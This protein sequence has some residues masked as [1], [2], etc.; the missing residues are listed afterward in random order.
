MTDRTGVLSS[1]LLFVKIGS[2]LFV[3]SFASLCSRHLSCVCA[4][5]GKAARHHNHY[6]HVTSTGTRR[7]ALSIIACAAPATAPSP[8]LSSSFPPPFPRPAG[9]QMCTR[10]SLV[11]TSAAASRTATRRRQRTGRRSMQLAGVPVSSWACSSLYTKHVQS[12]SATCEV[13]RDAQ[14]GERQRGERTCS[15]N[16]RP[17]GMSAATSRPVERLRENVT[18]DACGGGGGPRAPA[19]VHG[20]AFGNGAIKRLNLA[21]I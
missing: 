8:D 17:S 6:H 12:C 5:Q 2:N 4:S 9:I 19:D 18:L 20:V 7:H 11:P 21:G 1:S 3:A 16:G 10:P 15:A 13:T 14:T